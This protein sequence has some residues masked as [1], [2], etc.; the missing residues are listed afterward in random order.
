MSAYSSDF[1]FT[2]PGDI[3]GYNYQSHYQPFGISTLI[4]SPEQQD[5]MNSPTHI[6]RCFSS[7]TTANDEA[8]TNLTS[9]GGNKAASAPGYAS[10]YDNNGTDACPANIRKIHYRIKGTAT[11]QTISMGGGRID[12]D[13]RIRQLNNGGG[14]D[15]GSYENWITLSDIH[16]DDSPGT[17]DT[18]HVSITTSDKRMGK[19]GRPNGEYSVNNT[20]NTQFQMRARFSDGLG[21]GSGDSWTFD[22]DSYIRIVGDRDT[23]VRLEDFTS[24]GNRHQNYL[25]GSEMVKYG[26]NNRLIHGDTA[27]GVYS[28]VNTAVNG[29]AIYGIADNASVHNRTGVTGYA[30]YFDG[31]IHVTGDITYVGSI[32]D[33]SDE[34]LKTDITDVTGSLEKLQSLKV[35]KFRWRDDTGYDIGEKEGSQDIGLVAQEV[36]EVMPELIISASLHKKG[37]HL[38]DTT[39][40]E[41]DEFLFLNYT[42]VTPYLIEAIQE[43]QKQIEELKEEIEAL[44]NEN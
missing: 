42:K 3:E 20:T 14:A 10:S 11:G 44:K 35:K 36:Q 8:Y 37:T 23:T 39:P 2:I 41:R 29:Y 18:G 22:D 6:E 30:G 7:N 28:R 27:Y 13:I 38:D 25:S 34:R 33:T 43:Q 32:T 9:G 5:S 12:F 1:Q 31:N 4:R 24:Y 19:W 40:I 17:V 15:D 26:T 16:F 21:G